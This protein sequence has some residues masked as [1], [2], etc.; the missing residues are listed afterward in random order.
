[1]RKILKDL[2]KVRSKDVLVDANALARPGPLESGITEEYIEAYRNDTFSPERPYTEYIYDIV[3]ETRGVIIYQEQIIFICVGIA[4]YTVPQADM[5]RKIIGKSKGQEALYEHL[6]EFVAGCNTTSGLPSDVAVTLFDDL[7]KFGRYGFNRSHA[8]AYTELALRQMYL[9]YNY[10]IEYMVALYKNSETK[11]KKAE[12]TKEM[13]R[14]GIPILPPDINK[15]IEEFSLDEEGI[16]VGLRSVKQVGEKAVKEIIT[17]RGR[18]G[19]TG[20]EDF[21]LKVPKRSVNKRIVHNLI[22]CGAFDSFGVNHR[23]AVEIEAKDL[24]AGIVL[25]VYDKEGDYTQQE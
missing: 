23:K 4:G 12:A 10:P 8:A 15:S 22:R 2:G 13:K 5:I 24:L 7:A 6:D 9:K 16:R 21:L 3:K 25:S 20:F 18:Q 11:E 1:M 14:L 19:F 17:A